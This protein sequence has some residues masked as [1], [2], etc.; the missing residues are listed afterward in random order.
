VVLLTLHIRVCLP[1]T[2]RIHSRVGANARPRRRRGQA[3]T[4]A[5]PRSRAFLQTRR[6]WSV[7]PIAP[8]FRFN[9][10]VSRVEELARC[11]KSADKPEAVR[12]WAKATVDTLHAP[13]HGKTIL[14]AEALDIE[15]GIATTLRVRPVRLRPQ[16]R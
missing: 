4:L 8:T 1:C 9:R 13:R 3:R 5:H 15:L 7:A 12:A 14:L 10:V 6:R 2:T 11:A 16:P